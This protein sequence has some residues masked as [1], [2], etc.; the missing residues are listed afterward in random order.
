MHNGQEPVE[1]EGCDGGSLNFFFLD[2][3]DVERSIRHFFSQLHGS[4]GILRKLAKG[5]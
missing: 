1:K 2:R 5:N 3:L 4:E